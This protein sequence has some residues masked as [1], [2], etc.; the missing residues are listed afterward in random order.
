MLLTCK[1]FKF[2]NSVF[3]FKTIQ[4]QIFVSKNI[5]DRHILVYISFRDFSIKMQYSIYFYQVYFYKQ[6]IF[7]TC[8]FFSMYTYFIYTM[9]IFYLTYIRM[10]ICSY[11]GVSR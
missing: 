5:F 1:Y 4:F 2:F 9:F 7:V 8:A 10:F 11:T 3:S 6:Y